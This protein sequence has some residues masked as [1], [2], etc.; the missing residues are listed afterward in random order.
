GYPADKIKYYRDG[1][2]GW[3]ILGLTTVPGVE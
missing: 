1:M 3:A 2:Q